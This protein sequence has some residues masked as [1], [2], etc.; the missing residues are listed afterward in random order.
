MAV[1]GIGGGAP[2]VA[3]QAA[4]AAAPAAGAP[5]ANPTGQAIDANMAGDAQAAMLQKGGNQMAFSAGMEAQQEA[6]KI[7]QKNIQ[8]A[9]E[10]LAESKKESGV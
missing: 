8:R 9:K 6:Q 3:P 7:E 2:V 5:A 10:M 4:T 1:N